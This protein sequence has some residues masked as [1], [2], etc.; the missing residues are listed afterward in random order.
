MCGGFG[1]SVVLYT[2]RNHYVVEVSVEVGQIVVEY[3]LIVFCAVWMG[4]VF[5]RNVVLYTLRKF[6]VV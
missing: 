5:G 1:S 4:A 2:V 3:S 6:S